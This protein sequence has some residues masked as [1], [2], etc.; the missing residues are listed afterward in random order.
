MKTLKYFAISVLM[1]SG[2][3]M[4]QAQQKSMVQKTQVENRRVTQEKSHHY[5]WAKELNLSAEQQAKIKEIRAKRADE[6]QKLKEEMQK[7]RESERQEIRNI[8]TPEQQQKM[9]AQREK[10]KEKMD[11]HRKGSKMHHKKT[12]RKKRK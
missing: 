3:G 10:R 1:I 6:K 8:L 12:D 9:D 7:L 4:A 5:K 11:Q 2:F